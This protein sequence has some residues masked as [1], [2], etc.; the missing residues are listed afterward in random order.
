MNN[1]FKTDPLKKAEE[2]SK[3]HYQIKERDGE[4]WITYD[5]VAIIPEHMLSIK[6]IEAL[7]ELRNLYVQYYAE[8]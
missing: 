8:T 2:E 4:I 6:P 3:E 5:G 1:P 7:K